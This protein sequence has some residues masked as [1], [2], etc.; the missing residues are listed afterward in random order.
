ML[1]RNMLNKYYAAADDG[2][3]A[4]GAGV[5]SHPPLAR[6]P[7]DGGGGGALPHSPP[8]GW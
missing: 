1:Y 7:G 2:T 4:G 6:A 5:L 3:G 8:Q